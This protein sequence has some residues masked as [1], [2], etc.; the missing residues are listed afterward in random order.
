MPKHTGWTLETTFQPKLFIRPS[1]PEYDPEIASQ[2]P[3]P[4]DLDLLFVVQQR[5]PMQG[6]RGVGLMLVTARIRTDQSKKGS[7]H[8]VS[9]LSQVL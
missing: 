9:Y 6:A 1:P 2:L 3:I 5:H 8:P 7:L 4:S